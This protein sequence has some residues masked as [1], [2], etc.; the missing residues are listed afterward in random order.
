MVIFQDFPLLC[1]LTRGYRKMSLRVLD[2]ESYSNVLHGIHREN[3]ES[4]D[5]WRYLRLFP[6]EWSVTTWWLIPRL[7]SGL[8]HPSDWSGL[9][10]PIPFITGVITHLR[11]VASSPPSSAR[12]LPA[13]QT[14]SG[15]SG[16]SW[17]RPAIRSHPELD[18]HGWSLLDPSRVKD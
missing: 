9:T 16:S 13:P 17:D 5:G 12:R 18:G 4:G 11:A 15:S 6:T 7:V 10:L 2:L 3:G 8:V 14:T 1:L